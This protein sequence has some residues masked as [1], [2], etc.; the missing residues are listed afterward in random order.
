M[1][2]FA[3]LF[4]RDALISAYEAIAF[5]PELAVA[6]LEVLAARQAIVDDPRTDAEPGKILHELRTGEMARTGELPFGA[7]YGSVDATPLWLILLGETYDWTGDEALV[8]RLWPN[9]LAALAWIDRFGDLD[10]D[11][12][13]EYRRRADARP[14]QPGLEGLGRRGPRPRRRGRPSR[15]SRW[16]RSR[17][18]S[19]T[20]SG[21][22]PAWP[23]AAASPTWPTGSSARP[24]TLQDRFDD[25]V[26]GA[27]P[28]L[29]RDGPRPATSGRWTRIAS[30]VGQA[31][32]GGIVDQRRAPR[33]WSTG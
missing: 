22:W 23:G 25:G 2:W 32:W 5:R 27:R 6:T 4:G 13:V 26:L 20:P 9:A 7:Y 3:T 18:T 29:L 33:P 24:T 14:H 16:P 17:A 21:G 11:G 31:L 8:D 19:T 15:R 12:F 10:G 30:N 1:P 28:G